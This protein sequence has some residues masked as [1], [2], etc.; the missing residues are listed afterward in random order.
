MR[1]G[2]ILNISVKGGDYSMDGYYLRKYSSFVCSVKLLLYII[3]SPYS[4]R[5][6]FSIKNVNI[7]KIIRQLITYNR[8]PIVYDRKKVRVNSDKLCLVLL[9]SICISEKNEHVYRLIKKI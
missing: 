2:I 8:K 6:K 7:S 9:A 4:K 1:V 5:I 3:A